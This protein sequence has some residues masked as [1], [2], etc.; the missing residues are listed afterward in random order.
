MV[1]AGMT[2]KMV[3]RNVNHPWRADN[4]KSIREL[5]VQYR[6]LEASMVEFFQQ[7]IDAGTVAPGK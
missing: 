1:N 6:P 2:R 5:G 4:S 7:M 3:A